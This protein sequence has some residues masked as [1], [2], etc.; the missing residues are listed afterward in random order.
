MKIAL[1]KH[2]C[3]IF[4]CFSIL[5]LFP[6]NTFA[7]SIP[8]N[9]F[10]PYSR[11]E[12]RNGFKGETHPEA[13]EFVE[14][15]D[16]RFVQMNNP[17][18]TANG[19][20]TW[21]VKNLSYDSTRDI[22]FILTVRSWNATTLS[23][24]SF[25]PESLVLGYTNHDLTTSWFT[26]DDVHFFHR[27]AYNS[28]QF[29]GYS[30]VFTVPADMSNSFSRISL[31]GSGT[32]PPLG[33]SLYAYYNDSAE[34]MTSADLSA[35]L[36]ILQDIDSNI[37]SGNSSTGIIIDEFDNTHNTFNDVLADYRATES[38]FFNQFEEYNGH[39]SATFD[40]WSWGGLVNC[41]DWVGS[42]LT[43]YYNNMGDFRQYII[44][45]L[46]LGIALFFLGRGSSIIGHLYRKPTETFTHIER[47]TDTWK[48]GGTTH[49]VSNV[50]SRR[51]GG[52]FRK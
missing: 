26:V 27:D 49:S 17:A 10:L 45:P 18:V 36:R 32:W 11:L 50:S 15:S 52:K 23:N 42:T 37:E 3:S 31:S 46:M 1:K 40:G 28:D 35:I 16:S 38:V 47:M 29:F 2:F 4:I 9:W 19:G 33:V 48:S 41:A 6:L 34:D 20:V 8:S 5:F 24:F 7:Y 43:S 12:L 13:N 30:V 25:Y 14:L 51:P 44:Y 39:L 21:I 22:T